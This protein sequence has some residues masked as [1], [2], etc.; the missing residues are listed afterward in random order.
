MPF[1]FKGAPKNYTGYALGDEGVTEDEFR[2]LLLETN[3]DGES[4]FFGFAMVDLFSTEQVI[5][6]HP[7]IPPIFVKKTLCAEDLQG[8][9]LNTLS[10]QQKKNLFPCDENVF[11]YHAEN[12]LATSDTLLYYAKKGITFKLKYFVQYTRRK[13]FH[14]FIRSMVADRVQAVRDKDASLS[15]LAK[16]LQNSC[17]GNFAVNRSR[18]TDTKIVAADGLYRAL[19]NPLLKQME[20][21]KSDG[22]RVDPL[23]EV[24]FKKKRIIE[25]LAIHIQ[26]F[27]YQNS[28]LLFFKFLDVL[29]KYMREGSYR[30]CYCDT[31]S[32]LLALT[33][34]TLEE[35]VRDELRQEWDNI[36]V[37]K[38]FATDEPES[39]KEPGLLKIEEQ[40]TRGWFI[41]LS[42][43]CYIM[44][45]CYTSD[46]EKKLLD[47]ANRAHI[48]KLLDEYN[49]TIASEGGG[50][51]ND[52]NT[53]AKKRSAK[54]V[55]HM[56]KLK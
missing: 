25:D 49:N 47:P 45:E 21:L 29:R 1:I 34:P 54:G 43:K 44:S 27:V 18:F 33:R 16:F 23:H 4:R 56:I 17:V 8:D 26:I 31:D 38:W 13:P 20:T 24:S 5:A 2:E 36:I 11:C 52:Q 28:K 41:A 10:E 42:P 30:F 19:R 12:Y 35:H 3:A 40:I 55:A 14:K 32:F 37:K 9:L 22:H 50:G 7:E 51:G 15:N 6:D 46:F 39:Q 48:Y 53:V